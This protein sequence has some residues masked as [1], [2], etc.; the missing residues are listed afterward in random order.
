MLRANRDL[1]EVLGQPFLE[2][3]TD[4]LLRIRR[5]LIIFSSLAI[6]LVVTNLQVKSSDVSGLRIDGIT[7]E[8]VCQILFW[9]ILYHFIHFWHESYDYLKKW[10]IRVTANLTASR[11]FKKDGSEDYADDPM[12]STLYNWWEN[13]A[14]LVEDPNKILGRLEK[15][16]QEIQEK[17]NSLKNATSNPNI[18][19]VINQLHHIAGDLQSQTQNFSRKIQGIEE[20]VTDPRIQH[21]L[22]RFDEWF[23]NYQWQQLL[24]LFLIEWLFPTVLGIYALF[25]TVPFEKISLIVLIAFTSILIPLI[26]LALINIVKVFRK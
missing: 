12:Q 14:H 18:Q 19:N 26:G 1:S 17:E 10:R 21:S 13:Q 25:S 8:I 24:R 22:K 4:N 23:L 6:G 3:F 11:G 7:T 20:V 5:N 16:L 9:V 15:I 2:N